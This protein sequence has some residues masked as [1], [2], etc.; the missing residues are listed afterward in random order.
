MEMWSSPVVDA[1]WGKRYN[2][3]PYINFCPVPVRHGCVQVIPARL[4]FNHALVMM[5]AC[6]I[7]AGPYLSCP[8]SCN[9]AVK[10]EI[11]S[12]FISCQNYDI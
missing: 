12:T 5:S 1:E 3:P 8:T 4:S 2:G 7:R 6:F 10:L 9:C 11:L